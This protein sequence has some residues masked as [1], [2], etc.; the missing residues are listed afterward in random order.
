[1]ISH[2]AL[3]GL[4]H[5]FFTRQ[6]GVSAG[7]YAGRNVGFGSGDEAENIIE[8]RAR[9]AR[10]L[11]YHPGSLL[12][13]WQKH[14]TTVAVV[15]GLHDPQAAPIADALV[16]TTPGLLLGVLSA[17]CAPVLLAD[18]HAGVVAAAHA[19]WRGAVHGIL[20]ETVAA[21]QR[22]GAAPDRLVAVIGP[23]IGPRSYEVGPEFPAAI[24][25]EQPAND[26]FFHP[27]PR[28]GHWLFDLP[29]YI[30]AKLTGL[31]VATVVNTGLDTLTDP[32]RFYSYRRMTLAGESRYG[33]QLSA[34]GLGL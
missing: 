24:L 25:A 3:T 21:M 16:T 34:I 1:M 7:L 30:C 12:T 4:P 19:G 33:R 23:C 5:G 22:L 31:G 20:N 13:V 17:D 26:R 8:N 27:S 32:E 15:D 9:C 2:A 10:D 14:T 28:A 11:G 6:N 29:G 18:Y